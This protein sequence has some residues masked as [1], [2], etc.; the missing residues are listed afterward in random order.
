MWTTTPWTL[1]SNVGAAIGPDIE[2][3]R[4]RAPEA[5]GR[6][7]VHGARRGSRAV[8]GDDAEIVETGRGRRTSSACTTSGRSTGSPAEGDGWRVVAADFVT[9]ED[10][11]GIVH[12]APAF[13]EID[14]EVA[15]AEGLPILNPVNGAARFTDAVPARRGPVRQGRRPR[16][17]RGARASPAG[18]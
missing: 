18:S 9:T 2:Y 12:L 4:V 6:D 3:V 11:S 5:G 8:L 13:G 1:I 17:H 15:E 14:R 16:P 7:L 10:G